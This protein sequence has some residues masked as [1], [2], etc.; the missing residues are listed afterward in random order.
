MLGTGEPLSRRFHGQV[1][2][3]WGWDDTVSAQTNSDDET[4]TGSSSKSDNMNQANQDSHGGYGKEKAKDLESRAADEIPI[5]KKANEHRKS[6]PAK[7][8][9]HQNRALDVSSHARRE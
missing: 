5:Y 8:R 9:N 6:D 4:Q 3:L 1:L 2:W 7:T